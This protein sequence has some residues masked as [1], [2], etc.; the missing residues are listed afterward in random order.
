M[1]KSLKGLSSTPA[2]R[3]TDLQVGRAVEDDRNIRRAGPYRALWRT[4]RAAAGKTEPVAETLADAVSPPDP[5]HSTIRR[6]VEDLL[7]D[8][9]ISDADR[10]TILDSIACPCC[11]GTGG[12][13]AMTIRP[14]SNTGF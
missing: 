3:K 13:F 12:S 8:T 6:Q 9:G 10:R 11:G 4:A 14:V 5:V 2:H 1:S 7:I